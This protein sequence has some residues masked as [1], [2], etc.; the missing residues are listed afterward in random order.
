MAEVFS[1]LPP[2]T[3]GRILRAVPANWLVSLLVISLLAVLFVPLFVPIE[4]AWRKD[5]NYSHGYLIPIICLGL[6]VMCCGI[7]PGLLKPA[8]AAVPRTTLASCGALVLGLAATLVPW[9]LITYAAF[10]LILRAV[11]VAAGGQTWAN[12]FTAPIVFAFFMFPVPF[13]WTSYAALWLQEMVSWVSAGVLDN[14]VLC[15]RTGTLIQIDGVPQLLQVAEECSGLRQ[16][17][18]FVAFAVLLGMMLDRPGWQR[19]LLMA[20]GAAVRRA[21]QRASRPDH[22][23]RRPAFW[24]RLD[25]RLAALCAGRLHDSGRLWHS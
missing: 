1:T 8:T 7:E 21:G 11:A 18:G 14:F 17:V 3:D 5:P 24:N 15:L 25:E 22:E 20:L 4:L 10:A 13:A 9:P 6:V 16:I 2:K 12:Y 23:R 19:L